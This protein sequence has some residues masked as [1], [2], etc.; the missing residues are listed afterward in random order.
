[1]LHT[2][3][4]LQ[5]LDGLITQ[6][7]ALSLRTQATQGLGG[8][9]GL[10]GAHFGDTQLGVTGGDTGAASQLLQATQMEKADAYLV[11]EASQPLAVAASDY[12]ALLLADAPGS[13]FVDPSTGEYM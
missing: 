9:L 11:P 6:A 1:M 7:E 4:A 12:D 3:Q 2:T 10:D 5:T 13:M 8:T